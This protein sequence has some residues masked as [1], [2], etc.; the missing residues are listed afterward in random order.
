LPVL[1][2]LKGGISFFADNGKGYFQFN[3]GGS[4][5]VKGVSV[6]A[7]KLTSMIWPS[8]I[9]SAFST[10]ASGM[11]TCSNVSVCIKLKPISSLN[12]NDRAPLNSDGI[13]FYTDENV[14]SINLPVF[15]FSVLYAQKQAFAR[16]YML[17]LY[18]GKQLSV[19][20]D[21]HAVSKICCCCHEYFFKQFFSGAKINKS[22]KN[23]H[24]LI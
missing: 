8:F 16:F 6:S 5:A 14:F 4:S 15:N 21:A 13:N 7:W 9:K 3:K 22:V 11:E 19:E 24:I 18:N 23:Q 1:R 2:R 12:R 17:K 10:M 20:F